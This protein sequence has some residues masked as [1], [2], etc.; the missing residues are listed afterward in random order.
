M[1]IIKKI[2]PLSFKFLGSI[3]DLII[4][5]LLHVVVFA[6]LGALIGILAASPVLGWI[7]G[8]LG[9]LVDLY[10]LAGIVIMLLAYFKVLKD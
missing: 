9:G 2:F 4:G 6:L 5:I 8:I 1:D 7:I 3:V 10:A